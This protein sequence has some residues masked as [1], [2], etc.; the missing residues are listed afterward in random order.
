[1]L[2]TLSVNGYSLSPEFSPYGTDY[3]VT[4]ECPVTNRN[5]T[6]FATARSGITVTYGGAASA[7]GTLSVTAQDAGDHAVTITATAENGGSRTYTIIFRQPLPSTLLRRLWTDVIAVNLDSTTNGGY[8]FTEFSW[9]KDGTVIPDQTGQYLY[10]ADSLVDGA[11]YHAL[12]TTAAGA[13][14]ETCPYIYRIPAASGIKIYPNPVPQGGTVTV[15]ISELP[16]LSG[17][18]EIYNLQGVLVYSFAPPHAGTFTLQAPYPAGVYI[19]KADKYS[20]KII[21][22]L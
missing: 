5:I 6:V 21:V 12:L 19:I 16:A 11:K 22:I 15:D 4:L 18:I 13:I 20:Q 7:D 2:L 14:L 1:M 10:C 8:I 9:Y 17:N 3:T